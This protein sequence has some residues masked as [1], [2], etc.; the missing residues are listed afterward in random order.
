M[1]ILLQYNC[2]FLYILSV[3]T[4]IHTKAFNCQSGYLGDFDPVNGVGEGT[5]G[6]ERFVDG[7]GGV[8][9]YR[10]VI[11]ILGIDI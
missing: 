2:N 1:F 11:G 5:K 4:S 10:L 9:C 6:G 7:V 8:M 3:P